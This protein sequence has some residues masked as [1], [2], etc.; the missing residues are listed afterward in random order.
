[1]AEIWIQEEKITEKFLDEIGHYTNFNGSIKSVYYIGEVSQ[2]DYVEHNKQFLQDFLIVQDKYPLYFTFI[3]YSEKITDDFI[4][5]FDKYQYDY[6]FT[7][8]EEKNTFFTVKIINPCDL[9]LI[10]DET[11]WLP[12][13]NEFYAISYSDNLT[14]QLKDVIEW[15]SK[16]KRA[17]PIFKI[18]LETTF[19]TIFHDGAGFYLFS[20]EERYSTVERLCSNFPKETE[21]SQ[22][23]DTL[24][25]KSGITEE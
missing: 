9:K 23:N 14:I 8:L 13:Q 15:G 19:I 25:S 3:T 22:K 17:L 5:L 6:T 7:Y 12:T 20:N 4:V 10:L 18:D 24:V 2:G 11:Y 1:M 21:I 16:M